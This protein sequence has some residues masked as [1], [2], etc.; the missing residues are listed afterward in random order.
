MKRRIK[1]Q[2]NRL[3]K[4]VNEEAKKIYS[5]I[6]EELENVLL[7]KSN[8]DANIEEILSSHKKLPVEIKDMIVGE[9]E[10]NKRLQE[11]EEE[12]KSLKRDNMMHR[13]RLW[14]EKP[15]KKKDIILITQ[16]FSQTSKQPPNSP[17]TVKRAPKANCL[18]KKEPPPMEKSS[19]FDNKV[20]LGIK[21]IFDNYDK[22]IKDF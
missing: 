4:E 22:L 6:S 5:S 2:D 16:I 20:E 13:A 18:I 10:L 11:K 1:N 14:Q 15:V 9:K 7:C 3:Q 21:E 17:P 12:L 19:I 8:Q